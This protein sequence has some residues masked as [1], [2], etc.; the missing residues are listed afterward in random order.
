MDNIFLNCK[1]LISID[2]SNFDT[3]NMTWIQNMFFGCLNL[4][5]I[6]FQNVRETNK[7]KRNSDVFKD[8]PN[9][10]IICLDQEKAP[11]LTKLIATTKDESCYRI[12][13]GD[14]WIKYQKKLIKGSNICIDKYNN[15]KDY[16]LDTNN[17]CYNSCYYGY[18]YDNEN[19]EKKDINV[20]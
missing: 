19:S 5:Y 14:D 18:F 20:N 11:K 10:L 6:N 12:Y 8:T 15:S 9:N 2:L 16:V 13:Y 17:K 1:S 4:E 3:S 7:I